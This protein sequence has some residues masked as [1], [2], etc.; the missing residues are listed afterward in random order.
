MNA[1][2]FH[3]SICSSDVFELT[4]PSIAVFAHR[5]CLNG[6][7]DDGVWTEA[8]IDECA[9]QED[10][11][12]KNAVNLS[13]FTTILRGVIIGHQA[14]CHM[15]V[16]CT[17]GHLVFMTTPLAKSNTNTWLEGGRRKTK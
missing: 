5:T 12:L 9:R 8:D 1:K 14:T 2:G 4:N 3:C 16:P 11:S 15:S 6:D 13:P 17:H 10:L 7:D